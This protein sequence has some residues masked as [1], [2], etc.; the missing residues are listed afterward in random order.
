MCMSSKR[1]KN[2]KI[3]TEISQSQIVSGLNGNINLLQLLGVGFEIEF[4]TLQ[5][6]KMSKN[7]LKSKKS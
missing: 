5:E 6:L 4:K 3:N 2:H 7:I 1:A